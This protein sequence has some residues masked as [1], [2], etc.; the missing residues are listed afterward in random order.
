[1]SKINDT[2]RST[3]YKFK[4]IAISETWLNENNWDGHEVTCNEVACSGYKLCCNSRKN[5]PGGGVDI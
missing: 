4:I 5:M 1:M 3:E 2:I